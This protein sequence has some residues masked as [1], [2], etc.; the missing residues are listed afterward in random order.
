MKKLTKTEAVK[1]LCTAFDNVFKICILLNLNVTQKRLQED[2]DFI[3]GQIMTS[4]KLE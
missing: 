3:T 2:R 4:Y 1:I